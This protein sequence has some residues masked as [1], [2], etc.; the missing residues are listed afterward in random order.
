MAYIMRIYSIS[1]KTYRLAHYANW[2][3]FKLWTNFMH[4][5]GLI[6]M[7]QKTQE[8]ICIQDNRDNIWLL[9]VW[10]LNN[11]Y[12]TSIMP[13]S[14]HRLTYLILNTERFMINWIQ[15]SWWQL[16]AST[17]VLLQL[18]MADLNYIFL[19]IKFNMYLCIFTATV[20][21]KHY[22]QKTIVY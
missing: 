12:W 22:R 1:S 10:Q 7:Q 9:D 13:L 11:L 14:K 8:Q 6:Q 20:I 2:S 19:K 21:T 3:Y 17:A 4:A 18:Y 15:C 5:C 16:V